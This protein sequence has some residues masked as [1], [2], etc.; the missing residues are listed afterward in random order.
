MKPQIKAVLILSLMQGIAFNLAHPITPAFVK[1]LGINP[2]YFGVFFSSMSLGGVFGSPFWGYTFDKGNVLRSFM[3]GTFMYAIGQL[4]FAFSG[5]EIL[6][7]FSRFFSGVGAVASLIVLSALIVSQSHKKDVSFNLSF[8]AATAIV[9]ASL[10]YYGGG[11]LSKLITYSYFESF[12]YVFVFQSLFTLLFLFTSYLLLK[13]FT[14]EK[15]H[16]KSFFSEMKSLKSMP[17]YQWYFFLA[18]LSVTM[19]TMFLSRYVDVLFNER[20]FSPSVI[21]NYVLITGIVSILTLLFFV[22][23]ILKFKPFVT[24]IVLLFVGAFSIFVTFSMTQFLLSMYT[25]Y[26][27]YVVSKTAFQPIEHTYISNFGVDYGKLMGLRQ[28]FISLG[29]VL[30]PLFLGILF[31]SFGILAFHLAGVLLLFGLFFIFL[32]HRDFSHSVKN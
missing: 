17:K 21:G 27:I 18:I 30:G 22:P 10:G 2:I 26:L 25:F 7:V 23:R 5:H 9:G 12:K 3:I 8:F 14:F 11:L 16:Q 1:D 13:S 24:L 31:D 32:S 20:G 4:L 19:S 6:M 15:N 28:F 29:M